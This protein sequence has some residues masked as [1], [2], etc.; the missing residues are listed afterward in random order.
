[1]LYGG[2][3][4]LIILLLKQEEKNRV[5]YD[6]LPEGRHEN[7]GTLVVDKLTKKVKW[8]KK[9]ELYDKVDRGFYSGH[10]FCQ[11]RKYLELNEYP[12]KDI[13]AWY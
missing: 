13:V 4:R 8:V 9:A 1:M 10:A 2:W 11:L 3:W 6:Y 5:I 7:V 12:K